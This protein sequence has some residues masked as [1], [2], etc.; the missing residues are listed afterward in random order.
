MVPVEYQLAIAT[1]WVIASFVLAVGC[2]VQFARP[3]T[4]RNRDVLGLFLFAPGFLHL[5]L[6][7]QYVRRQSEEDL[8]A[9]DLHRYFAFS[10]L[11]GASALW[12]LRCVIDFVMTRRPLV[13]ANLTTGG[14]VWLGSAILVGHLGLAILRTNDATDPPT[15]RRPAA[16]VGVESGAAKIVAAAGREGYD[17]TPAV[18]ATFAALGHLG[19]VASLW[20]IG[21]RHFGSHATG[22]TMAFAYLLVPYTGIHFSKFHHV[23]PAALILAAI[24]SYRS[25][26]WAGLLIGFAAGTAYFPLFLLPAWFQF[27]RSRR[28]GRF[29][30]FTLIGLGAG[31][32][33]ALLGLW[34][35]GQSTTN[36]WRNANLADWMPW[37]MPESSESI[38]MRVHWAYRL[39]VFVGYAALVLTSIVWPS[40]RNLGQL[41]AVNAMILLGIQFWFADQGGI[42]V[43]WYLPLLVLMAF[44]PSTTDM[45]P[46]TAGEL[47]AGQS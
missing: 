12:F 30:L 42:Y 41:I 5:I 19:I 44:R 2:F 45:V 47:S 27:Y 46:P 38:W 21:A 34:L 39:P 16:V 31:A 22:L 33:V 28:L 29:A 20:T 7:Q 9:A 35:L 15:G 11:L 1:A 18:R 25:A 36:V 40:C 26:T 3:L 32:C 14:I 4:S 37:R 17:A 24:A 8:I 13:S 23:W 43:L 10:W 6:V